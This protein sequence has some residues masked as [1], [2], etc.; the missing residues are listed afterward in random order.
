[1][2]V[3]VLREKELLLLLLPGEGNSNDFSFV[4]GNQELFEYIFILF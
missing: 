2:Y 4:D 3:E 1:M